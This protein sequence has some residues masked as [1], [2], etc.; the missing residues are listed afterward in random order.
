MMTVDAVLVTTVATTFCAGGRVGI[1]LGVG[2]VGGGA[3]Q[4][5]L[6]SFIIVPN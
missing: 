2:V 6:S 1:G 3:M 4:A 5:L